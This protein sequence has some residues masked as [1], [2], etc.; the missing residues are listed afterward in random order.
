MSEIVKCLLI[1]FNLYILMNIA[2]HNDIIVEKYIFRS[3]AFLN[4]NFISFFPP[5]PLYEK[6]IKVFVIQD[7]FMVI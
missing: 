3:T 4:S 2:I 5:P 1:I 7:C 6:G